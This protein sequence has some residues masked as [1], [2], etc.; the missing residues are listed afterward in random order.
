MAAVFFSLIESCKRAG[1][2]TFEYVSDV[3]SRIGQQP[4]NRLD[5][6]LPDKWQPPTPSATSTA[7]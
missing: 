3:L 5:E 4:A 1:H 7:N 6:L 2:N